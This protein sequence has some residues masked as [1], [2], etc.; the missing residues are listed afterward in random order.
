MYYLNFR[1]AII[2]KDSFNKPKPPE[3][4]KKHSKSESQSDVS[5]LP[6]KR[7][8]STPPP[9]RPDRNYC[10]IIPNKPPRRKS[11]SSLTRSQQ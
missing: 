2:K 4:P 9:T 8:G 10:T 7:T 3:R 11:T 1:Y 6:P 5:S